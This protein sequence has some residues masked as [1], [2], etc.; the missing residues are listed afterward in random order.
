MSL[1]AAKRVFCLDSKSSMERKGGK[2]EDQR[3]ALTLRMTKAESG[4]ALVPRKSTCLALSCLLLLEASQQLG[5][6]CDKGNKVWLQKSGRERSEIL[7]EDIWQL[8]SWL[9]KASQLQSTKQNVALLCRGLLVHT[10]CIISCEIQPDAGNGWASG[11]SPGDTSGR[12]AFGPLPASQCRRCTRK[13]I[14]LLHHLNQPTLIALQSNFQSPVLHLECSDSFLLSIPGS[15]WEPEAS[16]K[17][18]Q[19]QALTV[20]ARRSFTWYVVHS[21]QWVDKEQRT[22]DMAQEICVT[23]IWNRRLQGYKMKTKIKVLK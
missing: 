9:C 10:D 23:M 21:V 7:Q 14:L 5:F 6:H 11:L 18:P 4:F 15:H 19:R 17:S 12:H 3:Q 1:E 8:W 22:N 20:I 16:G 2:W 13:R